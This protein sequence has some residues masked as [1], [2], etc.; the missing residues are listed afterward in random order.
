M[1]FR[2]RG[3]DWHK[4]QSFVE[5]ALVLPILTILLVGVSEFGF[6]FYAYVQVS[7]AAREGARAGSRYIYDS[8]GTMEQ[9]DSMRGWG[10]DSTGIHPN[11]DYTWQPGRIWVSDAVVKSLGNLP[12]GT[13]YLDSGQY[14]ID[15]GTVR[16]SIESSTLP[17]SP[18][19]KTLNLAEH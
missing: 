1:W 14:S 11:F 5:F 3:R 2:R 15:G 18:A 13:S 19:R 8:S 7:N 9:N 6:V 17:P 12:I 10:N 16:G 4:G